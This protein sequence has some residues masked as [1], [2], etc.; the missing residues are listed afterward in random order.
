[1]QV[2]FLKS[3]TGHLA[4]KPAEIIVDLL[5]GK[6]DV[7]EFI[8]CKKLDMTINQTRNI[9]YKLSD[10]G[11]VSFIRKKDKK[12]GWYIYY[13]TLNVHTAFK[14][15]EENLKL[16]LARFK[17]Q[18]KS[19]NEKRFYICNT[20]MLEVTEETALMN[21]FICPE[22]EE[23][24]Q[25]SNKDEFVLKLEKEIAKVEKDLALVQELKS[26]E[27]AKIGKKRARVVK[28]RET[29]KKEEAETRRLVRK[30]E[31]EKLKKSLEKS[32]PKEKKVSKS[33]KKSK[34]KKSKK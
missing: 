13:W 12:K 23:V 5:I 33:V 17:E 11:V 27:E 25:L 16:E 30:K 4:G 8:I 10:Y 7:N 21:D 24:Y 18:L 31:R 28:K 29:K 3:I 19:R 15:L 26:E 14:L 9:L 20:C 32:A 34:L 2:K 6:K 1:M 22:C